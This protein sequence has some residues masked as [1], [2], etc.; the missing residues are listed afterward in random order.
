[1]TNVKNKSAEMYLHVT[2]YDDTIMPKESEHDAKICK[3]NAKRYSDFIKENP[4]MKVVYSSGRVVKDVIDKIK[5][6]NLPEPEYIIGCVGAEIY[7]YRKGAY[8]KRWEELMQKTN[9]DSKK[10]GKLLSNLNYRE[11]KYSSKYKAYYHLINAKESDITTIDKCLKLFGIKANIN[12]SKQKNI[13]IV[14]KLANKAIAIKYVAKQMGISHEKIAISG[15]SDND[16]SMFVTNFS[17][18][19]LPKNA[20]ES[21]KTKVENIAGLYK[22][23]SDRAYGVVEGLSE[24]IRKN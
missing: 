23:K 5:Q 19:I 9:F 11:E 16:Y 21:L 4:N 18:K 1:M 12:Y 22:C 7:D 15:D 14:P 17:M 2:D 3:D 20:D 6:Y 13:E 8:I 10:I 24:F